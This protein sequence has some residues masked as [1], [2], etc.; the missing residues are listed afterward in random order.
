MKVELF[1]LCDA[2]T[3]AGGKLNVLGAFD[4]IWSREAPV[5]LTHCAVAS[6]IRFSRDEEGVHR[7]RITFADEDGQ[8]VLPPMESAI[9]LRFAPNDVSVPI[10]LIVLMPQLKLP[11]FGDYTIDL[12][13]DANHLGS[14]PLLVRRVPEIQ[15]P[16][17]PT[18]L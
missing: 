9:E 10:N 1:C 12:A 14:L 4:R 6:R 2:A 7:I 18:Q 17:G 11:G 3:E 5:T 15:S 16:S 8:L 13:L